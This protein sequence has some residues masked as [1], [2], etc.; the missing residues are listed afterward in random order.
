MVAAVGFQVTLLRQTL[1]AEGLKIYNGF[2]FETDENERTVQQII[3]KFDSFAVGEVNETYERY[4]FNKRDQKEDEIFENFLSSIRSV[5]K[6]CNYCNECVESILRDRIVLGVRGNDTKSTLLR[7]RNLTLTDAVDT[8]KAAED[9]TRQSKAIENDTD[10]YQSVNAVRK[11]TQ[12]RADSNRSDGVV[13]ECNFCGHIHV[14][15]IK[16]CPA[17]GTTCSRCQ[18]KNHFPE[19]R[20]T[21]LKG[22]K[23][24]RV[25]RVVEEESDQDEW[26]GS[27]TG[28]NRKSVKCR[29]LVDGK[30]VTFMVDTGTSVNILSKNVAHN[31][32][33]KTA[34]L[35]C[36]N[37]TK[38]TPLGYGKAEVVNP[39]N[40]ETYEVEFVVVKEDYEPLL[41]LQTAEKMKLIDVQRDNME[42]VASICEDINPTELCTKKLGTLPGTV[43]FKVDENVKPTIMPERRVALAIRPKLKKE[44]NRLEDLGVIAPVTKPT[45]R[46]SQI[47]IAR[48]KD[49][50]MRICLDPLELNKCLIRERFTLPV[51]EEVLPD[52]RDSTIFTK[53]DLASGYW[54]CDLDEKSSFLTTLQT[55]FGRYRWLRLPFGLSVSS[56]IFK[57]NFYKHYRVCEMF[58]VLPM[59]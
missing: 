25:Y 12:S 6:T 40:R 38:V 45:Q 47:C 46:V 34:N 8:C 33:R 3:E 43:S 5:I 42:I 51:L 24:N 26:I 55:C 35:R 15:K 10:Q 48:K 37:M 7:K 32:T 21:K 22:K 50:E 19:K 36:W 56:E 29:L 13:R 20:Y 14:F 17:Y 1:G 9:A 44:L 2:K 31:Y 11:R 49:S 57:G 30:P 4:V 58:S 23:P 39:K 16:L 59:M 54:H 28:K 52:I 41:S 53:V 18:G 27:V